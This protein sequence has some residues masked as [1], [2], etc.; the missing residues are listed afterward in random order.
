M[1]MKR[2]EAAALWMVGVVVFAVVVPVSPQQAQAATDERLAALQA[3]GVEASLTVYPVLL[4]EQPLHQVGSVVAVMMEQAGLQEVGSDETV[5]RPPA[6]AKLDEIATAFGGFVREQAI[7]RQYALYAEY[8][9]SRQTG[10]T[11]IRAVLVD[12]EGEI[13]WTD[14]QAPGDTEFDRVAPENPMGC[15]VL[16]AERLSGAMALPETPP[17]AEQ[18]AGKLEQQ[19]RREAGIPDPAEFDAMEQRQAA[20]AGGLAEARIVVYPVRVAGQL[21]RPQAE[22]LAGLLRKAGV[23]EAVVAADDLPI[24]V[25][26]AMNEQKVLWSLARGFRDH[27]R[28]Q[29]PDGDYAIYADYLMGGSEGAVGAVHFVLC[30]RSGDWVI[31]DF[32]NSHHDD[33][34]SVNPE[35]ADDCDR[36]A[37]KR[38]AGYTR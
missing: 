11:G 26:R 27:V 38:F 5:F 10:V 35:S 18:R 12:R 16:L 29:P 25:A 15:C 22:Q 4:G 32:Q 6:E 7:E 8:L 33:F 34:Q 13:V 2:I 21:S 1:D 3:A 31:V 37:A 14:S 20:L 28:Q 17:E 36:L 30:D 23:G 24:D 19:M 9:G